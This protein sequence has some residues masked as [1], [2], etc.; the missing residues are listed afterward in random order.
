MA[1]ICKRD[2]TT[3]VHTILKQ[4]VKQHLGQVIM[5]LI[6][7]DSSPSER[8]KIVQAI[9]APLQLAAKESIRDLVG[10]HYRKIGQ[11]VQGEESV[12]TLELNQRAFTVFKNGGI[13]TVNDLLR[14]SE[15]DLKKMRHCGRVTINE[16]KEVLAEQGLSLRI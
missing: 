1:R 14:L 2:Y 12:E 15:K 6:P 5:E 3:L 13:K 9:D 10:E 8:W 16:I 11:E 7:D 4:K